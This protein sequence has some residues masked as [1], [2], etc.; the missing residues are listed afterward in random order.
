M[1]TKTKIN[2]DSHFRFFLLFSFFFFHF[3]F[4]FCFRFYFCFCFCFHFRFCVCF[5]FCFSFIFR[6]LIN[7]CFSF[8]FQ[9]LLWRLQVTIHLSW[10]LFLKSCRLK[11]L[12][13]R[14]QHR[15][16]PVNI[17]KSLRTAFLW[18]ISSGCFQFNLRCL[19]FF[20]FHSFL[21][22]QDV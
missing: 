7:F 18:N 12:I 8:Y 9:I 19:I 5:C 11:R 21:S 14:L 3:V 1:K 4:H 6:F 13:K 15:Y 2:F 20:G 22:V 16:F 17:A 10:S